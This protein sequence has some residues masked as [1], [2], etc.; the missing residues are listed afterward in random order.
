VGAAGAVEAASAPA[1]LDG[2]AVA[3]TAVPRWLADVHRTLAVGDAVVVRL[4]AGTAPDHAHDVVR[5]AG[6]G[7]AGVDATQAEVRAEVRVEAV[8]QRELPDLVGPGM[9]LLLCGLNPSLNAADAGIGFA[10]PGNRFWPAMLASGLAT[11]DRD[12]RDLLDRH[13]IGMTDLVKRATVGAAE[14]T[15]A[16]YRDGL[17]RVE[18]LGA[19]LRPRA[20]CFLGLDGWRKAVDRKA[21]AGWQDRLVGGVAAY[22]MPN[23]SGLN[24]HVTVA[25]LA[26]HL[27]AAAR[28]SAPTRPPRR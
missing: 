1:D 16:D 22:V 25:D 19:W 8:R 23:P 5:G 2:R 10:R 7:V 12:G 26:E 24:A 6:F 4:A 13:R 21:V 3:A 20:I 14:L 15:V 27:R 11:V 17:A 28:R 9:R 18:R